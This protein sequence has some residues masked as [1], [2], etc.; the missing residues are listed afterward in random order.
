MSA[1]E[2]FAKKFGTFCRPS[3]R[4]CCK[5]NDVDFVGVFVDD[6]DG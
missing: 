6:D 5:S 1:K 2:S 3:A 4:S